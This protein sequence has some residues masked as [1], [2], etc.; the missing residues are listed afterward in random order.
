MDLV[1]HKESLATLST[2]N[3]KV[4]RLE[5]SS[6]AKRLGA[7][8][9]QVTSRMSEISSVKQ[10][11]DGSFS[12]VGRITSALEDLDEEQIDAFVLTYRLFVQQNDRISLK[13]LAD[14]YQADWMPAEAA[15]S[16]N[17]ARGE[18]NRFLASPTLI[19]VN[20][21]KV[22]KQHLIHTVLYGGLA[23]TNKAKEK[24]YKS[25]MADGGITGFVWAEFLTGLKQ[26]LH[27]LRFF[28]DLNAAVIQNTALL[29]HP[30]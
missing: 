4:A 25:W 28:R 1:D 2:F 19:V 29:S 16:F 27:Y 20:N 26:M 17:D 14:I 21:A 9:V 23:H 8:E 15:V 11:K 13:A 12:I 10:E 7:T 6:L 3:D 5:G 18:V 30:D 24:E 22:T